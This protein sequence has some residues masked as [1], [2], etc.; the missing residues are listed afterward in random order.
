MKKL[1]TSKTLIALAV[2]VAAAAAYDS[3]ATEQPIP[4]PRE[5]QRVARLHRARQSGRASAQ[6]RAGGRGCQRDSYLHC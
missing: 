6:A 5:R 4:P 2:A 3:L 1:F